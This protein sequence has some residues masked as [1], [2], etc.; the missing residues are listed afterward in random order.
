[1][2][3]HRA[4]D[5]VPHTEHA[6]VTR[7]LRA[8]GFETVAATSEVARRV[9]DIQYEVGH[10]PC[11]DAA[12]NEASPLHQ[13]G[14]LAHDERWLI[15]GAR[16]A[17]EVDIRS[18]LSVRFFLEDDDLVA[19]LNLYSS[20]LNAFDSSDRNVAMLLATHGA[21]AVTAARAQGEVQHL[22]RALQ[23]NRQI[24][25]AIG[26]LMASLTVTQDQAFSLLRVASQ[27]GHRKLSD[28]A[29][30]VVDTGSLE[31]DHLVRDHGPRRH[32]G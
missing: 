16:A 30:D 7:S 8:G 1:V 4:L 3:T 32:Q 25:I 21:L 14:D 29:R 19:S 20:Q 11:I 27:S 18:M 24:G 23:S 5:V 28:V 26:I 6:G 10:G 13:S 9:D 22:N 31:I 2:L 12:T 15:F 17:D